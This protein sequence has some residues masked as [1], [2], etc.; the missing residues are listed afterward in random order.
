MVKKSFKSLASMELYLKERIADEIWKNQGIKDVIADEISQ[1]VI[2]VVYT[3]HD[4]I[5][6]ERRMDN[7]GL[8]DVRNVDMSYIDIIG[9]S[10]SVTVENLT[11]GEDNMRGKFI[12]D[13]IEEGQKEKWN[14]PNGEWSEPRPFMETARERL[15]EDDSKLRNEIKITLN[16]VGLKLKEK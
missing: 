3:A 13:M 12:T 5:F 15:R 8:S 2:D 7:G 1:A 14:N 9:K 4:P 16:D 10:V 11:E 6:Y